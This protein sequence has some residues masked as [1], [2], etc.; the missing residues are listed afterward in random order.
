MTRPTADNTKAEITAFMDAN[1]IE[2]SSADTKDQLLAKISEK[3][4]DVNG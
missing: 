3:L 4:G 1:D 2:Y